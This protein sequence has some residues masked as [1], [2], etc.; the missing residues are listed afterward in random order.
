MTSATNGSA[1]V[2]GY[3]VNPTTAS[4]NIGAINPAALT[5][6]S[7]AAVSTTY[8]T[9][10]ATGAVSLNGVI[11]GDTVTSTASIVSPTYSTSGNLNA[12][13]YAQSASSPGGADAG[14]YTLTAYTTPTNNYS[15]GQLALTGASIAASG[16]TYG[17]PLNPGAVSFG[18]VISGDIVTSTAGVNTSTVSSSGNPIVGS[19]T[20]TAGALAGTDAANYSFAGYTTPTANYAVT[21]LALVGGITVANKVYDAT[22]EATIAM[23]VVR[24]SGLI[25]RRSA[26]A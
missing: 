24:T 23:P 8:G 15:V 20:Q 26:R 4:A 16:S 22:T 25:S 13:S 9:P 3:S 12:G 11:S 14:N 5:V 6:S 17:S 1:S 21:Q 18:N 7:I 2:Y 10:A 19:Y